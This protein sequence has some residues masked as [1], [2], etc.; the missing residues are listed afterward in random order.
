MEIADLTK[1]MAICVILLLSAYLWFKLL[2]TPYNYTDKFV[3]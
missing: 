1:K 2:A 3:K